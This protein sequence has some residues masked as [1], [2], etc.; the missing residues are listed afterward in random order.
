MSNQDWLVI[1]VFIFGW[2]GGYTIRELYA[3]HEM[4]AFSREILDWWG[5]AQK[6]F[7][8]KPKP[9]KEDK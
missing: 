8:A 5:E 4:K 2:I 7:W 9:P 1:V 6:S 3:R